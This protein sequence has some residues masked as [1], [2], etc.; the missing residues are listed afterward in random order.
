MLR[1]SDSLEGEELTESRYLYAYTRTLAQLNQAS[2][3]YTRALG[4][5]TP[6]HHP[7]LYQAIGA[8]TATPGPWPSYTRPSPQSYQDINSVTLG[9][10]DSQVHTDPRTQVCTLN[11]SEVPH[12]SESSRAWIE[13]AE[14]LRQQR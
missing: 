8:A 1:S 4:R 12:S 9:L 14:L 3:S 11:T 6:G 13:F 5:A 10:P 7:Q 2:Q